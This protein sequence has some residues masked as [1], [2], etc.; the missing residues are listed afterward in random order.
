[1]YSLLGHF[2]FTVGVCCAG[3]FLENIIREMPKAF[4]ATVKD[5]WAG[6]TK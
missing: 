6:G 4:N 5:L 1:M 3:W 2:L